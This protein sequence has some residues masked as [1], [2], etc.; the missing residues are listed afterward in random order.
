MGD[1]AVVSGCGDPRTGQ[2]E[3]HS[4]GLLVHLHFLVHPVLAQMIAVV[5]GEEDEGVLCLV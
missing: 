1:R 4:D 5:R 2:D 3:G